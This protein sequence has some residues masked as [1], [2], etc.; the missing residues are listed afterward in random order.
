MTLTSIPIFSPESIWKENFATPL[1]YLLTLQL[2]L[3]SL[4][5]Y[6]PRKNHRLHLNSGLAQVT[7]WSAQ[8]DHVVFSRFA[9]V[10][11]TGVSNMAVY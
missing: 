1:F 7:I 3:K 5:C 8:T 4:N 2:L 10:F 11:R 6:H 9:P